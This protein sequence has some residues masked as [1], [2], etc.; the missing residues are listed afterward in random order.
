M[1]HSQRNQWQ[2]WMYFYEINVN[3]VNICDNSFKFIKLKIPV[4]IEGIKWLMF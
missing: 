1:S 2:Q 3:I 4:Y